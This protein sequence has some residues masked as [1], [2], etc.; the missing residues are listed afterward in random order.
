[1]QTRFQRLKDKEARKL[2]GIV[3]AGKMAGVVVLLGRMKG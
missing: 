1:M 3:L 2:V